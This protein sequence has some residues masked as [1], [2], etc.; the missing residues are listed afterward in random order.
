MNEHNLNKA[1]SESAGGERL[2][3]RLIAAGAPWHAQHLG[4]GHAEIRGR[5][6]DLILTCAAHDAD[7]IVAAVDEVAQ[8]TS[9]LSR[10]RARVEELEELAEKA[11]ELD[12]AIYIGEDADGDEVYKIFAW[13]HDPVKEL[14]AALQEI[15]K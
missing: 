4:S 11:E 3:D 13:P 2:V 15:Q 12:R 6:S 9:E 14:R 10:L 8:S 5:E 7:L 1:G